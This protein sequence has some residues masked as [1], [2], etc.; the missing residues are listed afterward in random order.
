KS[1]DFLAKSAGGGNR[2]RTPLAG[3]RILSPVRLPVPPPRHVVHCVELA[4]STAVGRSAGRERFLKGGLGFT[5]CC[6]LLHECQRNG[7]RCLPQLRSA[8]GG[9]VLQSVRPEG[10]RGWMARS[11]VLCACC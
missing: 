2:T 1:S 5:N 7:R 4:D 3:P 9:A 11:F 10:G 8:V 6:V